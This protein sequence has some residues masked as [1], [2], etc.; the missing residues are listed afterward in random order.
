[1]NLRFYKTEKALATIFTTLTIWYLNP[2]SSDPLNYYCYQT[3]LFQ[4]CT[5][6]VQD[7]SLYY[8]GSRLKT[9]R[10]LYASI[11]NGTPVHSEIKI[12]TSQQM[13]YRRFTQI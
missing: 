6:D 12:F 10:A 4:Q 11:D 8:I 13:K 1:M 7:L 5:L 3:I 9:N 2:F